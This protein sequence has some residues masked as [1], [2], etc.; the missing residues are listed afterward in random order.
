MD[1]NPNKRPT[2]FP[3]RGFKTRGL[4]PEKLRPAY[5]ADKQKA[6]NL[7]FVFSLRSAFA[8][9]V[10][11]PATFSRRQL[12]VFKMI[13]CHGCFPKSIGSAQPVDGNSIGNIMKDGNSSQSTLRVLA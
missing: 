6:R 3:R 7:R 9:S 13:P 12:C 8:S 5:S 10:W 11:V 2:P 1:H 4:V